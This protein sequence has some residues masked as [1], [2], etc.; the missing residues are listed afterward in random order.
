VQNNK[1]FNPRNLYKIPYG[2]GHSAVFN[3]LCGKYPPEAVPYTLVVSQD[4]ATA[5]EALKPVVVGFR[6]SLQSI[7][8]Q[9]KAHF[10][11]S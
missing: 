10:L 9:L 8:G 1:V 6:S 4:T 3:D 2:G 11:L 7:V 5:D